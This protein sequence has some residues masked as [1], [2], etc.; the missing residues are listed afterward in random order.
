VASAS[1]E[2]VGTVEQA[3]DQ[4]VRLVRDRPDLALK[5]TAEILQ[6]L[7]GHPLALLVEGM[8]RRAQGDIP[9]ALRILEPLARSQPTAAAVHFELGLALA[10][11]AKGEAAV[12]ALRRA[13]ELNPGLTGA[14]LALADHLAATGDATGADR[15]YAFHIRSATR[16]PRLLK[17]AAALCANDIPVAEALLRAYLKENP[18]DVAAIRMFAEVAARLGRLVD[19]ETLLARCIELAPSFAEARSHY[20]MV[21]SR[22]NRPAEALPHIERLLL[23]EPNNPNYRNLKAT[24]LVAI[25]EYQQAIDLYTQILAEYPNQAKVWLSFG[26]V[27]KTAGRRGECIHAYR[28]ALEL[29]P[30]FGEAYWSLA[31][32]KTFRFDAVDIATMR[33]RLELPEQSVEDKLHLHFA[34]GKACE[35]EADFGA[36]F[37]HY[38]AGNSLRR[39]QIAYNAADTSRLVQRSRALYTSEFFAARAGMG[40][41]A[42]DPIFIVGLPRSGSTL[43]EQILS[44]HPLVEGTMELYDMIS[45]ARSLGAGAGQDRPAV[46]PDSLAA[47]DAGQLRLLGEKYLARTRIQR[48]TPAPFFVDKMPN[49]LLHVGLIH[50]ALPNARIIDARR[51]P[52]GCCFSSFKQHFARG[53]HFSYSL[54]DVGR[55]Y[56]DYV[57][58]MAH[59]DT[60][61]PGRVYRV[62]YESMIED[63]ESEVRRLLEHCGLPFDEKCL[64][65]H[66]N[67]RAVRTAS[68]EQVRQPIF[69][70]GLEQWRHYEPWLRPLRAALGPVVAA[71]PEAPDTKT[72]QSNT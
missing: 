43:L 24:V 67:E 40:C 3:L 49:N 60:V 15:A 65:F 59:F 44:S 56:R 51:H 20:A 36:S 41:P 32:L 6:R 8:A 66:E 17:P 62:N 1:A 13:V 25:G 23:A 33:H 7:P 68:S 69:R 19:A 30:G 22:Q 71:Y 37:E 34:L 58:L 39:T 14:W 52:M 12:A 64:R 53:Q 29:A 4:A 10:A 55:Y 21:L 45:L 18:T 2:P 57:E 35:D 61:L 38:S 48:K 50:L 46:Y 16:D 72:I 5:Q 9:A 47:L 27:L 26:H 70:D 54:E 63:T 11:A 31:N 42:P 28:K